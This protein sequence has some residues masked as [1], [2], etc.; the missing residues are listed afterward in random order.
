MPLVE[1]TPAERYKRLE[2]QACPDCTVEQMSFDEDG[3]MYCPE[4][5]WS[6]D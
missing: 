5:G 2:R 1:R 6:E 3:I 4:C